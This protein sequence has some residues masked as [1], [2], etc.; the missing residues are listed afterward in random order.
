M[1][2]IANGNDPAL[3]QGHSY[4]MLVEVGLTYPKTPT[5]DQ[6]TALVLGLGTLSDGQTPAIFYQVN[7]AK[8]AAPGIAVA[9]PITGVGGAV[10][11]VPANVSLSDVPT[12]CATYG[13]P[14]EF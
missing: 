10:G 5:D 4:A 11:K 8:N 1:R 2:I 12:F 14:A 6:E 9:S 3:T 7:A 13:S